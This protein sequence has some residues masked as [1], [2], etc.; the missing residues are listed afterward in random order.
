MMAAYKLYPPGFQSYLKVLKFHLFIHV[1]LEGHA[2]AIVTVS[3]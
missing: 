3:A 2:C 1:C